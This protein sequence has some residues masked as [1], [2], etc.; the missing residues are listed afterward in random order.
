MNEFMHWSKIMD[1]TVMLYIVLIT[2]SGAL[3]VILAIIA[4]MN[5]KVFE[6]M[7]T[8]VWFACFTAIYA[9]GYAMCLSSL[10]LLEMKFWTVIQYLGMPFSAVTTLLLVLQYIGYDK[11]VT[12]KNTVLYYAIP[13]ISFLLVA[14]NEWHHTF[15]KEV[16]IVYLNQSPVMQVE[17]G[18]W[19]IIHGAYTFGTLCISIIL[20][21]LYWIKRKPK[22]WLQVLILVVGIVSPIVASFCYLLGL[23]PAGLDPVLIVMLFT[24]SLYLWAIIS[25]DFLLVPPIEKDHIFESMEHAVIVLDQ[26]RQVKDFNRAAKEQFPQVKIGNE[27]TEFLGD[28]FPLPACME[29]IREKS[30]LTEYEHRTLDEQVSYYQVRI[31][32]IKKSHQYIVGMSLVFMDITEQK[33]E[34]EL[35]KRLA[36][37]DAL[38][39]IYNRAYLLSRGEELIVQKKRIIVILFDIDRFKRINDTFGHH[40]GDEAIKHIVSVCKKRMED[41]M[42]FGRYGGEEFAL[43]ISEFDI[44]QGATF[45]EQ[46]RE[47][48]EQSIFYYNGAEIKLTASFGVAQSESVRGDT[49]SEVFQEADH[50]LY[51]SKN[52]GR[53]MVTYAVNGEFKSLGSNV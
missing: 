47:S 12:R 50:A 7:K 32:P 8:F 49:L 31:S 40:G 11:H 2:M 27:V 28:S 21:L 41:K 45:A 4:Y 19:Y 34:Q 39:E 44:Q 3:H 6:G 17:I 36:Y 53:N 37:T 16:S 18:Q 14:T 26:K 20:L 52:V 33:D 1:K 46:L 51:A 5:R 35:L 38:T 15:Y 9:F 22:Q 24:S 13:F 23:T 43:L 42:I 25:T 48:I 29:S 10:T 30:I